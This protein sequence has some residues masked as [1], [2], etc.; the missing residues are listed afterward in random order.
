MK[1]DTFFVS[2]HSQQIV[3]SLWKYGIVKS[4]GDDWEG[5]KPDLS[6]HVGYKVKLSVERQFLLIEW[7]SRL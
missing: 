2:Y 4:A 3:L 5:L 7:A 6:P 1:S